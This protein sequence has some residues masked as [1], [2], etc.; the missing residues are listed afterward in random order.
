MSSQEALFGDSVLNPKG[1]I[2]L[3]H[4]RKQAVTCG[5]CPLA[6]T[7]TNVVF[8]EGNAN[9]PLIAFVGEGP[10]RNEDSEG[11]PFVGKVGSF[12]NKMISSIGLDR[13]EVYVC[14]S[15]CCRP[16]GNRVPDPSEITACFPLLD[17]QL[18]I[19]RPVVIVTLGTTAARALLKSG[20]PMRKLRGKWHEWKGIPLRTTW[21]PAFLL[22]P[23]GSTHKKEAWDDLQAVYARVKRLT[24]SEEDCSGS[25]PR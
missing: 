18:L 22:R 20:A 21:H 1:A 6:K 12:L 4:V 23:Q 9:K 5:R 10:G 16:P 17:S 25:L 7:R 14:N 24:S 19:V 13:R 8:G 2:P 11:R 3:V 15:V